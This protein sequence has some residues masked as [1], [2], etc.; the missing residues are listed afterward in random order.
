M[1]WVIF[2]VEAA[3]THAASATPGWLQAAWID[4]IRNDMTAALWSGTCKYLDSQVGGEGSLSELR[5][6]RPRE[7]ILF[8]SG[9]PSFPQYLKPPSPAAGTQLSHIFELAG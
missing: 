1:S 7:Y 5:S 6:Q 2:H 8:S 4:C 9:G 3:P